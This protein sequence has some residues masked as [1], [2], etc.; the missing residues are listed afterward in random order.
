[1]NS[2]RYGSFWNWSPVKGVLRIFGGIFL[3][4]V[5]FLGLNFLSSISISST[6]TG[7]KKNESTFLKWLLILSMLGLFEYLFIDFRIGS[8]MPSVLKK[9]SLVSF[10]PSYGYKVTIEKLCNFSKIRYNMSNFN[11]CPLIGMFCGKDANAAMN[12]VH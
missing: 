4:A 1:M 6:E 12:R 7:L 3:K 10:I 5:A 2:N 9:L 8:N 11:Y